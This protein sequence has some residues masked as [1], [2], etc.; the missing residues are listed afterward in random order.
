MLHIPET[1]DTIRAAPSFAIFA[2]GNTIGYRA[3]ARAKHAGT[4]PVNA[5]TLDRFGMVI[6]CD[7]PDRA[8]E[9][10]R[11]QCNVPTCDA[12]FVDGICRVAEELRKDSNFRADFSTRRLVQ[13]ARL[14]ARMDNDVLRTSELAVVR[15][16][17]SATDA[18]VAR[19]VIRRI[20]GYPE[21]K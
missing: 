7:Y 3:T 17:E 13:W 16:L 10:E 15:K 20:F 8:E 9:I 1:R 18:K 11:V 14:I 4:N 6:A 5:A 19:Q 2:T 21:E 12:A